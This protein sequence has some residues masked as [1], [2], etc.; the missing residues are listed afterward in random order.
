MDRV[1]EYIHRK[2]IERKGS[3]VA[4]FANSVAIEGKSEILGMSWEKSI[5]VANVFIIIINAI[6]I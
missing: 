3:L 1:K 5:K 2:S 4:K 6:E